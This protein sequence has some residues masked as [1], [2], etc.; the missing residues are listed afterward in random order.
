MNVTI[1][2][3]TPIEVVVTEVDDGVAVTIVE[4][5]ALAVTITESWG[6]EEA[7]VDSKLYGRKNNDWEEVPAS[8]VPT[9]EDIV[10]LKINDS[11]EFADTLLTVLDSS[12]N[13]G[14]VPVAQWTWLGATAKSVISVCTKLI[15][16]VF[17]L[18]PQTALTFSGAI[19][20][21]KVDSHYTDYS[22]SGV[23]DITI[24]SNSIV[25]GSADITI[26]ADGSALTVTGATQ[27][28]DTA[29]D[30]TASKI[31]HFLFTKFEHGIYYAV[32]QLN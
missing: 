31:N 20:L 8:S 23:L 10:G 12:A 3:E 6:I 13:D 28:G 26:T 29:I 7:P 27:Y 16:K 14:S 30:Y 1:T 11:P 15:S 22:Q 18:Y 5:E 4:G 19:D 2:E 32:K 25:G 24:A 17:Y 9:K 21:T